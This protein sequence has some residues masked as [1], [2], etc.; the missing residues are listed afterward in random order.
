M[1]TGAYSQEVTGLGNVRPG[2]ERGLV[3]PKDLKGNSQ[4]EKRKNEILYES[5]SRLSFSFHLK[6]LVKGSWTPEWKRYSKWR[7]CRTDRNRN[8]SAVQKT[9][10]S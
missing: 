3:R 5:G 10:I 6:N 4:K 2:R 8:G 9:N 1:N 7:G